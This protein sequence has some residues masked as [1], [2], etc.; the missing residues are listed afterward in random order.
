MKGEEFLKEGKWWV[1]HPVNLSSKQWMIAGKRKKWQ[2]MR[3]HV[4]KKQGRKVA[5]KHE[6][7]AMRLCKFYQIKANG[8]NCLLM[9]LNAFYTKLRIPG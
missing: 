8:L 4:Y 6:Y 1:T 2:Q 3:E 7:K 9:Q 5:A